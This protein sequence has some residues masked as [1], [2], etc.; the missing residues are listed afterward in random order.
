MAVT[1]KNVISGS[2]AEKYKLKSG[3]IINK[4]N[5]TSVND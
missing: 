3:D 5:G 1:I 2:I 4:I